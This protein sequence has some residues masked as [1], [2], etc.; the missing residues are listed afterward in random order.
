MLIE[1]KHFGTIEIQEENI[2]YFEMGILGFEEIHKYGLIPNDDAESPFCWIQAIENP[3][4][5]FAL[6]NPFAIKNDYD[7][8]LND[9]VVKGLGIENPSQVSVYSI[10]VVPEDK[11]KISMNLKAPI[12]INTNNNKAAQ[13]VLDTD[14]YSVRHFILDELQKQE[15]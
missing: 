10:V 11:S 15:V 4:L 6:A 7:F 5:A 14:K 1:T 8:E 2:F 13:V 12:I 9:E 3:Q